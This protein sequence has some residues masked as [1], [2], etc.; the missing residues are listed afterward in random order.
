MQYMTKEERKIK[1]EKMHNTRDIGGYETQDGYYTKSH[2]YIRG[3]APTYCTKD[4]IQKLK[5]YGVKVVID[6]RS[7]FEKECQPNPFKNDQDVDFYELNLYDSSSAVL[8]PDEVKTYRNLGG[9]YIYMLEAFKD[10]FKE[11]FDIFIKY[12]YE[13]ILFHCSAGKDRTGIT[14]ALLL[15]LAGCHEYDIVKD[16]SESY[17][18]NVDIN[19]NLAEIMDEDSRRF[20]NSAPSYMMELLAYLRDHYGS[21]K[22]YLIAVGIKE[23][24]IIELIENF[25]I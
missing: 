11:L 21:A 15:D 22:E 20:L 8:V 19:E 12:P 7:D 25:K 5:D 23:E 9:V 6:L 10:K 24:E 4:D 13:G 2:K 1:L 3:A 17:E 18:N 14:A 16:Y